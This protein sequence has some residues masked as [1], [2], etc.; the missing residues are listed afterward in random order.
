METE[1]NLLMGVISSVWSTGPR[2]LL[3]RIRKTVLSLRERVNAEKRLLLQASEAP[4]ACLLTGVLGG[5]VK[6]F[7]PNAGR[8]CASPGETMYLRLGLQ[9]S[10]NPA[11]DLNPWDWDSNPAKTLLGT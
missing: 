4:A 1:R 7:F 11:W 5:E 8:Q 6:L 10:Q 3:G 2:G 9:P